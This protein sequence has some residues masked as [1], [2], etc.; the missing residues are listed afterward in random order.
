[1]LGARAALSTVGNA[2]IAGTALQKEQK[3]SEDGKDVL[4]FITVV[5]IALCSIVWFLSPS[6]MR[7][8]IMAGYEW[9]GGDCV[10]GVDHE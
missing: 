7:Q 9:R 5:A 4:G 8:C 10:M 3:M 6:P 2:Q 1:M